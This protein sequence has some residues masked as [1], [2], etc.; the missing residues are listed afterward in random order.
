M[1]CQRRAFLG[2][3]ELP[4]VS[5][6]VRLRAS[7]LDKI[8]RAVEL[9]DTLDLKQI[10]GYL[11]GIFSSK[12]RPHRLCRHDESTQRLLSGNLVNGKTVGAARAHGIVF[13][14]H[15]HDEGLLHEALLNRS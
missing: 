6:E 14:E 2:L 4:V 1:F 7:R 10:N 9:E 12:K 13:G 8:S 5:R 11:L 3:L 15:S